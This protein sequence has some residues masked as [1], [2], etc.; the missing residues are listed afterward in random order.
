MFK[1]IVE[2]VLVDPILDT[3]V[4]KMRL[5]ERAISFK[6]WV[7][8]S[9]GTSIAEALNKEFMIN[10]VPMTHDT[11]AN[12]ILQLG[13]EL[14]KVII[15]NILNN[16]LYACIILK[17]NGSTITINSRPSDAIAIALRIDAPIF[18]MPRVLE[19]MGDDDN[20]M[21]ESKLLKSEHGCIKP[22]DFM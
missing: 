7:G 4:L 3:P 12:I 6:I 14:E 15:T 22:E 9:E 2:D 13:V 5:E 17:L 18:I 20:D 21:Y 19:R 10:Q 8:E 1:V 11:M 16:I